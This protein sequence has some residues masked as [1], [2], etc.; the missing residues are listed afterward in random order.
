[1]VD[2]SFNPAGN[3]DTITAFYPTGCIAEWIVYDNNQR[4]VRHERY[5]NNC[6]TLR[7]L[8]GEYA[9]AY[10]QDK[11]G[12]TIIQPAP[13]PIPPSPPPVL[14]T[15]FCDGYRKLYN[16]NKEIWQD[17]IF[18]DCRLKDGKFYVYNSDGILEKIEIYKNFKFVGNGVFED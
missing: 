3:I 12:S 8:R 14:N 5:K 9:S 18:K 1:K 10:L 11:R 13:T 2:T 17:G 7:Y 6:D 16:D 15:D 4:E